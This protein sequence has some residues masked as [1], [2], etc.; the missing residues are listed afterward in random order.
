MNLFKKKNKT[1]F[2]HIDFYILVLGLAFGSLG[3]FTFVGRQFLQIL[4]VI[5]TGLFYVLWGIIHHIREGDYHFMIVL[6]YI[7]IAMIAMSALI[8]LIIRT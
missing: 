2:V 1:E 6:E 7:L 5:G 4:S 3:Y 8:A